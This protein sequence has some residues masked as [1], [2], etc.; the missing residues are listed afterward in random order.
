MLLKYSPRGKLDLSITDPHLASIP[1]PTHKKTRHYPETK[2]AYYRVEI[3]MLTNNISMPD[4]ANYDD[5]QMKAM[6]SDM[7]IQVDE[8]DNPLGPITK[9]M[10]TLF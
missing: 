5:T 9:K 10:G 1:I 6:N 2:E 8:N 7:C 3:V 4:E